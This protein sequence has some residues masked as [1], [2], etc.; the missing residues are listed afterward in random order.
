M[1][2]QVDDFK[3]CHMS[4]RRLA[5]LPN[6]IGLGLRAYPMMEKRAYLLYFFPPASLFFMGQV[7]LRIPYV[8]CL[9]FLEEG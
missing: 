4:V 1:L 8:F 2:Q 7:P 9:I 3:R 6:L 5:C